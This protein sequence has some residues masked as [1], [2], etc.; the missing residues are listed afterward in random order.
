MS[1][2]LSRDKGKRYER[3]VAKI[4]RERFPGL[5]ARRAS[6]ADRA[7]MP[8]VVLENLSDAARRAFNPWLECNHAKR[9]NPAK[10]YAQALL[11]VGGSSPQFPYTPVVIYRTHGAAWDQVY[12][13]P[14]S[15]E[16]AIMCLGELLDSLADTWGPNYIATPLN[17]P[18]PTSPVT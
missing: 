4:F 17:A 3:H 9:P 5:V 1:G 14:G 12:M 8:D 18:G 11:D 16:P 2:K 6:Q 15:F 7:Y 10:K 13:R